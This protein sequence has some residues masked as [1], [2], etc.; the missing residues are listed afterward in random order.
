MFKNHFSRKIMQPQT[1][2]KDQVRL[3]YI[4]SLVV[5]LLSAL[6]A[7]ILKNAIHYTQQILTGGITRESGSYLYLAYPVAGMFLTLLFVRYLVKDNIGHGISRVLYSISKKK[8]YINSH[9]SW[10]SVLASTLT[11]GF[12]GSVG[13]EAPI[14]LTGSSIGSV[15][16]RFFKLNYRNI[17]LLIGCGAAGAV[18]GI[19]KAPI[20]GIVFTLEILMLDLTISSIV[21]LLISSVTAAT[22]AYFLMGD[23]VLLTFDITEAF[24]ISNIPWY[25][26]LGVISGMISLYFSK[27]TLFL[28]GQYEKI[29]NVFIRLIIGGVILGGLIYLFPPFYGE[30]YDTI[31]LLLNGD[32]SA[33]FG[34][35]VFTQ[36]ADN[37]FVIILFMSGL[38][39][40]KVIASSSTNGAG[41]VGGIFAPT[42]FIGGVNGFLVASVLNH[43]FNVNIPDNRFVLVGMAG[44]M[45][46]VMHAPL[47]AIFLIAEIT[48]GYDLLIPLIITAT[49]AFITTRSFEKHSIYHVQLAQRGE[50]ITHDK[51]KAVLT[52]MD[53]KKEVETDLVKVKPSDTL[54]DLIKIIAR[55]KRNLFPVVDEYN[56]LEGV[57][58][59]DDVREIMFNNELYNTTIMR[60]LMTI[61]P[62]YIDKRENIETVMETFRKT[63]A[64][65]LPVLDNGYYVGFISK[66][67]I[68]STYRELLV[69]FSE[70]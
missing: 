60:D 58:L 39:L 33:V 38:V 6:A 22:V 19:F 54:G 16:G 64:W 35:S 25:I 53:W 67:R 59:L 61:P 7:A 15:I 43:F 11:I 45:A 55:S 10:T 12:G 29:R 24:N 1:L 14:V 47:T 28:E 21:P 66:S 65:N 2:I 40:L 49:V 9:N 51:D 20:A 56:I 5:G 63:G 3:T 32:T 23:K 44:L 57:V 48:G 34:N 27:M 8:S 18:S 4:L 41:G 50:L 70:E 37:Y 62:S 17:T 31:K 36:F 42:L 13:A 69:Q 30:G 68:Y 46:G 26:V 52:F